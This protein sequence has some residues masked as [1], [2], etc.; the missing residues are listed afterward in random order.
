MRKTTV[1]RQA[2][3]RERPLHS[4]D[5]PKTRAPWGARPNRGWWRNQAAWRGL[6][7]TWALILWI[8]MQAGRPFRGEAGRGSDLKPDGV[9]RLI[10]TH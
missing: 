4:I 2:A 10:R 3:Y 6:S 5:W 7:K 1:Q 9:P 8:P